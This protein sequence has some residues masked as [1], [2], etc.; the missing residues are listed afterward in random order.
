MHLLVDD[1]LARN[2]RAPAHVGR[3]RERARAAA[4]VALVAALGASAA[5]GTDARA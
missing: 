1:A 4:W 2:L 5:V 3:Q